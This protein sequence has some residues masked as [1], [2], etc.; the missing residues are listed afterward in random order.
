M[1]F[2]FN[3]T[4]MI[5][6]FSY[7]IFADDLTSTINQANK[8]QQDIEDRIKQ[9]KEN[10]QKPNTSK[11]I[12]ALQFKPTIK[13]PS[14]RIKCIDINKTII[15]NTEYLDIFEKEKIEKKYSN[16]CLNKDD[17]QQILSEITYYY[18]SR[19]YITTRVYLV[20]Q[21]LGNK[22][23][24]IKVVEGKIENL[25]IK[26]NNKNSISKE[27]VFPNAK[28]KVLNLRDIEQALDQ[29]NRLSSN[30]ARLNIEP[31]KKDGYS[32]VFIENKVSS[33]VHYN[34]A[35]DNQGSESTGKT[36][37][38]S[39]ITLD[40][41]LEAN[42]QIAYNH[43]K[44]TKSFFGPS[45]S[46]SDSLNLSIPFGYTTF[47]LGVTKSDYASPFIV[48]SGNN[49]TISGLSNNNN[50]KLERV[51]YRNKNIVFNLSSSLTTKR[52]RTYIDEQLLDVSS[53]K[54]TILD[55]ASN[56]NLS[57]KYG[58]F[59]FNLGYSKGLRLLNANKDLDNLPNDYPHF[60]FK[61]IKYAL[62]YS[63]PFNAYENK[64]SFTSSLTGQKT[65]H[66]LHGSEQISIG[67]L[68]SVRG[69]VDNSI[70]GDNGYYVR[71]E[72]SLN[73]SIF[74]NTTNA[75]FYAGYDY[76]KV[77]NITADVLNGSLSGFTYGMS[78]Y[79][80]TLSFDLFNTR[81]ISVANDMKKEPNMTWFR[82][83]YRF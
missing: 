34:F 26:D 5:I 55:L 46:S 76:G 43:T 20:P 73:K 1:T 25:I 3:F 39:S 66:T 64:M 54:F 78:L 83:A 8:I 77:W 82:I 37:I 44:T 50:I 23:L 53:K 33:P 35:V 30:N 80:K 7:N 11:G 52:T 69:F 61:K 9:E 13:T 2:F 81:P 18:I 51:F 10:F 79:Y 16:K 40:N 22:I 29:I 63:L 45:G 19:G 65:S 4:V 14:M 67:G 70:S 62:N 17:F 74:N 32:K 57:S 38:N 12:D 56:L 41:F 58:N 15:N 36:Q 48:P 27:N 49:L 42:E 47:Y 31:S 72:L 6:I 21:D 75:R 59:N 71:N 60:Q 68:S 24:N 28:D